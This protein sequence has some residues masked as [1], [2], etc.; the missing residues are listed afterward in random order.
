MLL[1]AVTGIMPFSKLHNKLRN[2][3]KNR[4]YFTDEEL[5]DIFPLLEVNEVIDFKSLLRSYYELD[6]GFVEKMSARVPSGKLSI[7]F[8]V[9]L[10]VCI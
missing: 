2:R 7:Y 5:I 9:S 4:S 1:Y 10:F 3:D 8:K 6:D